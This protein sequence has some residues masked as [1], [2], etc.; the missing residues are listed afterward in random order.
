LIKIS[1]PKQIPEDIRRKGSAIT[2]EVLRGD[3]GKRWKLLKHTIVAWTSLPIFRFFCKHY[4]FKLF[5]KFQNIQIKIKIHQFKNH[6]II[7]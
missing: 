6:R 4:L 2:L 3:I 7:F 5:N 1:L